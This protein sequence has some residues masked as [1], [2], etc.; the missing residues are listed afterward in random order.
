MK[1]KIASIIAAVVGTLFAAFAVFVYWQALAVI[2]GVAPYAVPT[3]DRCI[4]GSLCAAVVFWAVAAYGF[5]S[6]RKHRHDPA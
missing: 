1:T 3:N 4:W 6:R 2:A 5:A